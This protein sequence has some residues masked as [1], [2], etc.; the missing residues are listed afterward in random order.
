MIGQDELI[1]ELISFKE[2]SKLPN[3]IILCGG[4]GTGKKSIIK[5]VAN[6]YKSER[7][8]VGSKVDDIR[9][10]IETA[11]KYPDLP[12]LMCFYEGEKLSNSAKASLL[13]LTE[14]PPKNTKIIM[15]Y[16]GQYLLD[17]L[18]SRARNFNVIPYTK[19]TL[20]L[21][22]KEYF[23]EC[24]SVD[25]VI[26]VSETPLD[27][28]RLLQDNKYKKVLDF[29]N[30]VK[31]N[32]KLVDNANSLKISSYIQLKE[33]E[34]DKIPADL[35]LKTLSLLYSNEV[36]QNKKNSRELSITV[37]HLGL[38]QN[39]PSCN[40]QTLIDSLIMCLRG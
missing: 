38:L 12:K 4:K 14:E 7:V 2:F 13:K 15:T 24:N 10:G 5:Y 27:V 36:T 16:G 23:P 37:M 3:F 19:E 20:K 39:N 6:Y 28:I 25:D 9:M 31:N 18:K 11:N 17:T 35:F 29:C 21:I 33:D 8:I 1:K 30:L 26:N 40:K 34:E 22:A 32:I